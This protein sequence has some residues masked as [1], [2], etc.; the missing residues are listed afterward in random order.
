MT[1]AERKLLHEVGLALRHHEAVALA[2]ARVE[3]EDASL[4]LTWQCE[5]C[6]A[7]WNMWVKVCPCQE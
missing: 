5:E 7:R 6:G 1:K 2:L 3:D 4:S